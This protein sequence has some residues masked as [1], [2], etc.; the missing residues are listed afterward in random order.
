MHI[1]KKYFQKSHWLVVVVWDEL[2]RPAAGKASLGR[3]P[4][5][6]WGSWAEAGLLIEQASPGG[7]GGRLPAE[8]RGSL[9]VG[10]TGT[11]LNHRDERLEGFL[12]LKPRH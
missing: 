10:G 12:Y 11:R 1:N 6:A 8:S 3:E 4:I 9:R 5:A 7:T 2:P